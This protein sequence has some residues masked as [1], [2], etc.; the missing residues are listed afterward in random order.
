MSSSIDPERRVPT[1]W[2]VLVVVLT[3]LAVFVPFM[4]WHATWFGTPLSNAQIQQDLTHL[5]NPQQTQHALSLLADKI[6]RGD[7]SV[8]RWYPDVARL[9][10]CPIPQIRETAA[11]VMGQDNTVPEFHQTLLTL[12]H[13]QQPLVRMNAALG[14]VRFHDSSGHAEILR[15]LTGEP[16]LAPQGG[17]LK[18]LLNVGQGVN[19]DTI[20]A[21]I[22]GKQK[23]DVRAGSPGSLARWTAADGAT[24]AA[25]DPIAVL[26]PTSEMAR[27]ALR[28]LFLIGQPGDLNAIAP[29]ARSLPG[30]SAEVVQQARST[31][32]EIHDRNQSGS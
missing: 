12:L 14:L 24:V 25:G 18:R 26:S 30:M 13:D 15:M 9:A 32:Q 10:S 4:F 27:E 1:R 11:W 17:R 22:E 23:I 20:V 5:N 28:A 7:K 8:Q 31:M 6:I 16:L 19:S 3:L 29:Y 2:V 21:R